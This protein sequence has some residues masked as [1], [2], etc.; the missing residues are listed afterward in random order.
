MD[1]PDSANDAA[2]EEHHHHDHA[3]AEGLVQ[4]RRGLDAAQVH[5]GEEGG[6]EENPDVK[7]EAGEDVHG[8]LGA[9]GGADEGIDEVIHDHAPADH[10]AESGV[11]LLANVGVSRAGAGID[12]RHAAVTNG[13]KEHG[14]HGDEDGGDDVAMGLVADD[15]VD[16]HGRGGLD[17]DHADDDQVPQ[18]EGAMKADGAGRI[19]C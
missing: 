1:V 18:A 2:Q 12:T 19:A 3:G 10:V 9:E 17:D 14:D 15:A 6:E 5:P 13:G 7:G 11:H 8:G 16:A 4:L